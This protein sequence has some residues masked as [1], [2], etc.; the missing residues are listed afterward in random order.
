[1]SRIDLVNELLQSSSIHTQA[2]SARPAATAKTRGDTS[3]RKSGVEVQ[4]SAAAHQLV[5]NQ[6][7]PVDSRHIEAIRTA[8]RQGR[9]TIDTPALARKMTTTILETLRLPGKSG[10]S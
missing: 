3:G 4:L 6:G 8:I 9:Y 7:A 10:S 1:M 2:K 5:T